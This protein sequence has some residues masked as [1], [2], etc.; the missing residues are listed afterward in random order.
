MI[1]RQPFTRRFLFPS[2]QVQSFLGI[3]C[4]C[5]ASF[6]RATV[7][8]CESPRIIF[9]FG[10]LN[11]DLSSVFD[12]QGIKSR[13]NRARGLDSSTFYAVEVSGILWK[14][15][16]LCIQQH[17]ACSFHRVVDL[18]IISSYPRALHH[19]ETPGHCIPIYLRILAYSIFRIATY[20]SWQIKT[21]P[22]APLYRYPSQPAPP[23]PSLCPLP[24]P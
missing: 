17:S 23:I 13:P 4:E 3:C 16:S 15:A 11:L 6:P 8:I 1:L 21:A 18:S 7:G 5:Q 22:Q 20:R 10:E 14:R 19:S 24:W 2:S 12:A 9:P